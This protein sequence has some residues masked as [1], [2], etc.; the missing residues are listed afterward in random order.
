MCVNFFK[1]VTAL[2]IG[3]ISCPN[4]IYVI[5]TAVNEGMSRRAIHKAIYESIALIGASV[6]QVY[7]LRRLFER[8][9]GASRV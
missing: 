6:L 9:L 7:I 3:Y 2:W 4:Y 1:S 8:K 5:Q